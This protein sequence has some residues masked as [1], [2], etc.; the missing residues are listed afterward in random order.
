MTLE[1]RQNPLLHILRWPQRCDTYTPEYDTLYPPIERSAPFCKMKHSWSRLFLLSMLFT[2][3]I[4]APLER[5]HGVKHRF[6]PHRGV[7]RRMHTVHAK[8]PLN[9]TFT[10]INWGDTPVHVEQDAPTQLQTS[11]IRFSAT[12][13]KLGHDNMADAEPP[14]WRDAQIAIGST[15][16]HTYGSRHVVISASD[17]VVW[18]LQQRGLSQDEIP[19]YI[20]QN[21]LVT[22]PVTGD[23]YRFVLDGDSVPMDSSTVMITL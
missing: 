7:S 23:Q 9:L 21:V 1:V 8:R 22:D 10:P 15:D 20:C 5:G 14:S 6:F 19:H 17:P 18:A 4:S 3:T 16:T 13:S 2:F 11:G 12:L